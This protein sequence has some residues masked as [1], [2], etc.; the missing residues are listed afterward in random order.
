MEMLKNVLRWVIMDKIYYGF[1]INA[2][3]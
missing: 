1:A 3:Y 2:F